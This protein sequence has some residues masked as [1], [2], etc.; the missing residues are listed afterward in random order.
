MSAR[1]AARRA[2]DGERGGGKI[3]QRWADPSHQPRAHRRDKPT[4]APRP[5]NGRGLGHV[6]PRPQARPLHRHTGA[7]RAGLSGPQAA[8]RD[9]AFGAGMQ[10]GR[11]SH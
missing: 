8:S 4:S 7:G 5:V 3:R 9:R 11:A 2:I 10:R 1:A 6:I